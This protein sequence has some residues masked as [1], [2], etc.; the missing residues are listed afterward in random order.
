MQ[1]LSSV[2]AVQREGASDLLGMGPEE[3]AIHR[4]DDR[5]RWW[6]FGRVQW[7]AISVINGS[8]QWD[9]KEPLAAERGAAGDVD[10]KGKRVVHAVARR[11][12]AVILVYQRG[13]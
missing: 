9:L 5:L 7:I 6:P 10:A 4:S 12:I 13:Y 3:G 2:V 1:Q 8:R 11:V